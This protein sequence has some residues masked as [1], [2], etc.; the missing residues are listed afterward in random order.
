MSVT[1]DEVIKSV[2]QAIKQQGV[3]LPQSKLLLVK[4]EANK[5]IKD[6]IETKD[7]EEKF[8]ARFL[9]TIPC[10]I[11]QASLRNRTVR[12]FIK[13][14]KPSVEME[15]ELS[16]KTLT[17]HDSYDVFEGEISTFPCHMRVDKKTNKY[18]YKYENG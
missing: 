4:K 12:K 1:I 13:T 16:K 8:Y 11:N 10:N 18:S 7:K 3:S 14:I 6:L 15:F 9:V 5:I 2:F 17:L